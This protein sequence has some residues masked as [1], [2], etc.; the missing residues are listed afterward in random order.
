MPVLRVE[1]VM[2]EQVGQIST[3]KKIAFAV[4]SLILAAIYFTFLDW[5]AMNIQGLDYFY[6]FR[7]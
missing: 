2:A 5:F 1:G 3:G 4:G 7:K 6:M